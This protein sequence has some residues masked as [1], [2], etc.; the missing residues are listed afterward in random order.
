MCRTVTQHSGRKQLLAGEPSGSSAVT[1]GSEDHARCTR[2]GCYIHFLEH[3]ELMKACYF[4]CGNDLYLLL[5]EVSYYEP[6][7][8]RKPSSFVAT[9]GK[10]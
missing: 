9:S 7:K 3:N 5:L 8:S 4:I 10:S 6:D 2:S 1:Q